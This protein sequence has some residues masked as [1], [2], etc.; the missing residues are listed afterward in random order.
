MKIMNN[1]MQ[2]IQKAKNVLQA[3][4]M[5]ILVDDENRENEGDLVMAAE[6]VTPDAINFMATY[7]RGLICLTLT[8]EK[9]EQL[10]LPMMTRCNRSPYDT[11]FTVS[12]EA[13]TGVST[14]ISASDRAHTILTA[15]HSDCRPSDLIYPGHVFP[16]KA[17][18][19]G[20]IA[21]RGHTEGSIDLMRISGFHPSAV[22]CEIMNEDGTMSRRDELNL[23]SQKHHLPVVSI[24]DIINYRIQTESLISEEIQARIPIESL[25]DFQM[26]LFK[27]DIDELEHFVLYKPVIDKTKAPLVRVHS[28]CLTGDLLGSLKCDCGPQLHMSLEKIAKEGGLLIYLRQEGRGIGLANKLRAY[29]L[30]EQGLDTVDANISLGLPVDSRDYSIAYQVLKHFNW[31]RIRLLTNNPKKLEFLQL[32]GI[33]IET[34]EPLDTPV[35]A[36]N[37]KYIEIKQKKLGHLLKIK[38]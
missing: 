4:G 1:F 5:V 34:R 13:A 28:E 29:A 8:E 25:G 10:Q 38:K 7:G 20:V 32:Y 22:I 16:L 27:N 14:G 26:T 37:R 17:K 18:A 6:L 12:I 11:A 30:Q 21:R 15:I 33:E 35:N 2:S 23:F 24:Q 3:G 19:K 36:E 31:N 9:V